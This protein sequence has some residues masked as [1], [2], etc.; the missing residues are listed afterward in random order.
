MK[1]DYGDPILLPMFL[2]ELDGHMVDGRFRSPIRRERKGDH[3][4]GPGRA[5]DGRGDQELFHRVVRLLQEGVERL[6]ED[7]R[8][9]GVRTEE[10]FVIGVGSREHGDRSAS[11]TCDDDDGEQ[12]DRSASL[13]EAT[14]DDDDDDEMAI[15][16]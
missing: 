1:T 10:V 8:A 11:G 5:D 12:E 15:A 2:C 13:P 6:E 14:S 16:D 7:D 3:V 4:L 9:E